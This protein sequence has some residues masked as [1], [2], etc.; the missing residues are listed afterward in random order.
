MT[1][2]IHCENCKTRL[3]VDGD[4]MDYLNTKCPKCGH[5][6]ECF[7]ETEQEAVRLEPESDK[8]PSGDSFT[9]KQGDTE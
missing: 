2:I 5:E 7:L 9:N 6:I 1:F 3:E 4:S 8:V